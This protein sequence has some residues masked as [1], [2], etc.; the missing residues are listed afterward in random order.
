MWGLLFDLDGTLALTNAWH[1]VAWR[2]ALQEFGVSLS[3]EGYA[4]EISGRSNVE[5][6]GRLL[7]HLGPIEAERVWDSKEARFRDL[8]K[9]LIAPVGLRELVA[10]ALAER[11]R[12]GVVTNA[13]RAN[14]T[15]VI[16]DLGLKT[17]FACVV[18]VEDVVHPKPDP[19]PY[20]LGA[21]RLGVAPNRC[22]AFED[23][24]SG[25]RA[26]VGAGMEVVGLLTGHEP[27]Q[28]LEAGATRVARDFADESIR[29]LMARWHE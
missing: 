15:H 26:A 29:E 10:W 8:A 13:P 7:P 9:G 11:V 19:E 22:L 18:A 24:P 2:E 20:L 25:V 12:L 17:A 3:P 1:E 4:N 27:Q 28:L 5:I 23:S 6:V 14:A 16:A 21:K